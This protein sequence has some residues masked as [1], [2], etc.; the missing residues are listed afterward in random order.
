MNS[1]VYIMHDNEVT[2]MNSR[3]RGVYQHHTEAIDALAQYQSM[4]PPAEAVVWRKGEYIEVSPAEAVFEAANMNGIACV[5]FQ[6][7]DPHFG[8]RG[9]YTIL[10]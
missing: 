8:P 7:N 5:F 9:F 3:Q 6:D 1:T 10:E 2:P 4:D